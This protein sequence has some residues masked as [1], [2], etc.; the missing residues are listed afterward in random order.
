MKPHIYSH[1][2]QWYARAFDRHGVQHIGFDNDKNDPKSAYEDLMA[3]INQA[4]KL[5]PQPWVREQR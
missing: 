5:P 1:R 2:G 4:N 3:W